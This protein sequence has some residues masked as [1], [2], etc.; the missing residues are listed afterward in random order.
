LLAKSSAVDGRDR[1]GFGRTDPGGS[2]LDLRL[3]SLLR[4]ARDEFVDRDRTASGEPRKELCRTRLGLCDGYFCDVVGVLAFSAPGYD[5]VAPQSSR[6]LIFVGGSHLLLFHSA[7]IHGRRGGFLDYGSV[8]L[9]P[10]YQIRAGK[11]QICTAHDYHV[12][13]P[14]SGEFLKTNFED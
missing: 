13:L 4:K 1:G 10:D 7:I 12:E 6:G 14:S 3:E 2:F 9:C 8:R 11:V 5:P